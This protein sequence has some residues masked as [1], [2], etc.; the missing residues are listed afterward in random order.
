MA[1]SDKV[2]DHYQNPKNVGTLDKAAKKKGVLFFTDATQA[3]GKIPCRV[4]SDLHESCNELSA[5]STRG[6]VKLY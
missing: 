6:S 4:S 5:V 3:V 1:Y 2:I